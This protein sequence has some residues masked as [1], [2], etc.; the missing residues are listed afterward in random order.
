MGEVVGHQDAAIT[1]CIEKRQDLPLIP[2]STIEW[3]MDTRI[4]SIVIMAIMVTMAMTTEAMMLGV[5][6]IEGEQV[7]V[8]TA[9]DSAGANL[10]FKIRGTVMTTINRTMGTSIRQG[11]FAVVSCYVFYLKF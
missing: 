3:S 2:T 5:A 11:M 8:A 7:S 6:R 9:F 4:M 1:R 10:V